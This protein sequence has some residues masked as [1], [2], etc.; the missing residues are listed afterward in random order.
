MLLLGSFASV[1][2]MLAVIGIY[3]AIAYSVVQRTQEVGI[4]RASGAQQADVLRLVLRTRPGLDADRRRAR[5]GQRP[6][7]PAHEGIVV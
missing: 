3:G 5:R 6:A 7:H 1:A 2:L 4:R